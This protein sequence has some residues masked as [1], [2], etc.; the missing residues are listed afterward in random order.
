[1]TA[2]IDWKLEDRYAR[3][4]GRLFLTGTQALVKLPLLQA[5]LDRRAGLNT[6][7][8]ISGYR[9]SPLGGYD[10]ALW[11]AKAE[12]A[13]AGIVFQPGVN[14]DLAATAVLGSQQ[15]GSLPVGARHDGVFAIWYGKGP[16]VDR[17]IDALKHGNY[18]GSALNGGVLVLAGDDHGGKSSTIAFQSDQS[19]MAAAIPVLH[20]VGLQDY[21][22]LGLFGWALSRATG[23]WAGFKC[24]TEAV[25][26]SGTVDFALADAAFVVPDGLIDPAQRRPNPGLMVAAEEEAV[27]AH[28]LPAA[29]AFA[30]ANPVDAPLISP[31][32]KRLGIVAVGKAVGDVR[33]ALADL[34][35]DDQRAAALGLGLYAI[36]LAWPLER[37]G[38][39]RFAGGY[40]EIMV[41]E[42]K[43]AFV[44]AQIAEALYHLP[45]HQRPRLSG[46]ADPGGRPLFGEAGELSPS[47]IRRALVRRMS[48][49]MLLDAGLAAQAAALDTREL[50]ATGHK[51][52]AALRTPAFCSGCPHNRSTKIPDGSFALSGIGC[53]TMAVYMP[54]RPTGRPTQMGGEGA[55]WIGMSPFVERQHIFQN[56][57]DGTYFHSGIVAVRAAVAAKVNI[58]YKLL[59]NDAVAMTG[60]QP[61][62]GEQTVAGV[63][64]Q[65]LA[66]GVRPVIVITDDLA[67]FPAG[68]LPAG[69]TVHDRA[70]LIAIETRLREV[71]GVSAIVYQQTCAA[72]KRRRRKKGEFPDP[73][74]R[75]F[76]NPAVCEG[77][78][79]CGVQSNCVSLA[80]VETP[81]GTKR[82]IDQSSCNK[83]YSCVEG[84]CPSFVTVTGGELRKAR[85][86]DARTDQPPLPDPVIAAI[87]GSYNLMVTG[88]GGTGVVTIGAVIGM[89]AHLEGKACSLLDVTGL[90]QKNGAVTSHIRLAA[91]PA[92]LGATRIG[93]GTADALIGCDLLVS[94]APDIARTYTPATRV[95]LNTHF[96]PVAAFQQARDMDHGTSSA[97]A[98]IA[99]ATAYD[100]DGFDATAAAEVLFGN[101]MLANMLLMGT[102]W[103]K[104]LIPLGHAA[105]MRAIELNGV[106]IRTNVA[107]F[108]AGRRI[109]VEGWRRDADVQRLPATLAEVMETHA[110]HLTGYQDAAYAARYRAFVERVAAREAEV[111]PGST[112]LAVA[113]A[114]NLGKLMAYKDEYEVAR[115]H[116]EALKP[117]LDA[118]FAG[119]FRI[120]YNLAPPLFSQR[121]P[122]TGHLK[123]REFGGWMG[124]AFALLTRLKRLRGTVFDP[125][126][127]TEERRRERRMIDEYRAMIEGLCAQLTAQRL[128]DAVAIAALPDMVRGFGHVKEKAMDAYEARRSELLAN[129]AHAPL[130]LAA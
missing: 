27:F 94:A 70:E 34:G 113:V 45:A 86:E 101:A 7:G 52:A 31:Q 75:Y 105:L 126:G 114:R 19:L 55:N 1:M 16:G 18:H 91:A 97:L 29:L 58:T 36:R 17:S 20:P 10:A 106:A 117:G 76:I 47:L 64:G 89:A 104:G 21:L 122:V 81:F 109:A 124:H 72:E 26:S 42:E 61:V 14:E 23:L 83:D 112:Q 8:F 2:P 68:S 111:V 77:C 12:L 24:V 57:G 130:A 6:A 73:P 65:L 41:I 3:H 80:P 85:V 120:A 90:S 49:T 60:G 103:Q 129:W 78:G 116:R 22:R 30:R 15:A 100:G 51:A 39:G 48:D 82:A 96:V 127:R 59:F 119:A 28:R 5:E 62:D 56:L 102:A 25:D 43:R 123:K 71:K 53:H 98:M 121:D 95:A 37:E 67:R 79:D 115:L 87:N 74:K 40:D 35:L 128:D 44:A 9:G 4:E 93:I 92:A 84:F 69:I 46:K 66:E 50:A 99:E 63:A 54:D 38:L 88:I 110:Q 32:H 107:A 33:Q 13:A 125:F 118:Q 11:K 108:E